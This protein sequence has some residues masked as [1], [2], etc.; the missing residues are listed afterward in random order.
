MRGLF[1][2]MLRDLPIKQKLL[3]IV[4]VTTAAAL[5]LAGIA[6]VVSDAVL[7]RIRMEHDLT[8]LASI[9][10]DN[11][12]A[13]LTFDDPRVASETLAA[14]RARPYM[15]AACLFKPDGA[16]FARYARP[17]RRPGMPGA[18]PGEE[19]HYTRRG[20]V[21]SH[22]ILLDR[23]RIGTLV[24]LYGMGE[25]T[26]RIRIYGGIVLLILLGSTLVSFILS[27]RL[28]DII[29]APIS[30][31][32][33]A[34]GSISETG[35]YG[36]R[37][38]KDS[39]DELG[40]L[41]DS[42]NQMLGRIESRD[43]QVQNARNL[44]P[45]HPHQHRRRGHLDGCRRPHRV[46]QS[47]GPV[48]AALARHGDCRRAHRRRFPHRQ[49]VHPRPRG[50]SGGQGAARRRR[51]RAGQSHHPDRRRRHE[52]PIDDSAAPIRQGSQVI[53]VVLVFRDISERRRAQRDAA[54]LAAI[55]ESSDD[56]IIG[57]SPAGIIQSWNPG[58]QRVFGYHAEEAIGRP[59]A[60]LLPPDRGQEEAG[61]LERLGGG[62]SILQFET[63][64]FRKDGSP[65]DVSIT[66]SPIRDRTGQIIG[67]SHVV[68]DITEQKKNAEQMRQTQKLESLGVLAGGIAHD[69][70]N[71]LTGILGNA[72]LALD[73]LTPGSPAQRIRR[74]RH[75]RQRARRPTGPPDARLLREGTLR[76][77]AHRPFRARS[78]HPAL[79]QELD[80]G[81]A[82]SCSSTWGKA[83]PR[84]RP[85]PLSSSSSS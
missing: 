81:F 29:A 15:I 56:A 42:F 47:G 60:D 53:G 74:G 34:A 76:A 6:I 48:P 75:L 17:E 36:I 68:R 58:A 27:S 59:L 33:R 83:C 73:D 22:P 13:A 8:A 45:D 30:R 12:T 39:P 25:F 38:E 2:R 57:R 26:E 14:L 43:I 67:I 9:V 32:A 19:I 7:F 85:T 51:R 41:V 82:S 63:V 28:R 61:I 52:I 72:S 44:A 66:V 54:Y 71:L 10:G 50:E 20:L 46:R 79:D 55:V 1:V 69:F 80:S 84:S 18:R 70:N 11:S 77:G 3:V 16:L 23:R 5:L 21:V 78:R 64:R 31:L 65:V 24:L 4:L 35:D 37:V 40:V 49:R 62:G